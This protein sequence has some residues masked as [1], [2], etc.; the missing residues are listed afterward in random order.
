MSTL[1]FYHGLLSIRQF[2]SMCA[3]C[4]RD[5]KKMSTVLTMSPYSFV[6]RDVLRF[7]RI[8]SFANMADRAGTLV[9]LLSTDKIR[10]GAEGS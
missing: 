7:R 2:S 6:R 1:E 5:P 3:H 4:R 9:P 10:V 8:G